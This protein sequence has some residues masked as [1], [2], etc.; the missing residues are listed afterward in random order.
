MHKRACLDR[1]DQRQARQERQGVA[2]VNPEQE[3]A[4]RARFHNE[5]VQQLQAQGT[6]FAS[7]V[8]AQTHAVPPW[9]PNLNAAR[10]VLT[11]HGLRALAAVLVSPQDPRARQ[12]GPAVAPI[13]CH[14]HAH[15]LAC[16]LMNAAARQSVHAGTRPTPVAL[17]WVGVPWVAMALEQAAVVRWVPSGPRPQRRGAKARARRRATYA[18]M[19]TASRGC[20]KT[21]IMCKRI[22]CASKWWFVCMVHVPGGH[23]TRGRRRLASCFL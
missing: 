3:R 22:F 6:S 10:R 15:R 18:A 17:G 23:G 13:A 11:L 4:R 21:E 12:N 8:F 19:S 5:T 20:Q 2:P 9:H 1:A 7:T 14:A 16:V